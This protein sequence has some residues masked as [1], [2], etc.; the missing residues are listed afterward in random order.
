MNVAD[1][2]RIKANFYTANLDVEKNNRALINQQITVSTHQD[3]VRDQLFRGKRKIKDTTEIGRL[4][5]V[6]F[7]DIIDLF[8]QSLATHYDYASMREQFGQ[9]GRASCR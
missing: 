6:I 4:L 2:I 5:I 8:E 1:Y 9:I 3:N 7:T